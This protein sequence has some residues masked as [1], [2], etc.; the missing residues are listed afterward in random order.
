METGKTINDVKKI[1]LPQII[2]SKGN[3]TVIEQ[4]E[5]VPFKVKNVSWIYGIPGGE[6]MK[7]YSVKKSEQFIV[8]LSGNIDVVLSD[9]HEKKEFLLNRAYIGLYIPPMIWRR[10]KNF[11]TNALAMIL[12]SGDDTEL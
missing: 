8:A 2:N 7:R 1:E 10:I 4:F 5:H 12:S 3:L 6:G 11:S 9:G